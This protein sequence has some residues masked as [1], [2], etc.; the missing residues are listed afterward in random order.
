MKKI[1]ILLLLPLYLL[2]HAGLAYSLHF[3]AEALTSVSLLRQAEKPCACPKPQADKG[4][5]EEQQVD[6]QTDDAQA[7]LFSYKLDALQVLLSAVFTRLLACLFPQFTAG[8]PSGATDQ[9]PPYKVP[10]YLLICVFLI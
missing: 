6:I 1:V 10:L 8:V 7:S 4:C 3:C 2:S 9:P 5:C